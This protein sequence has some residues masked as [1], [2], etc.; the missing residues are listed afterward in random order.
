MSEERFVS[1]RPMK[2]PGVKNPYQYQECVACGQPAR[3]YAGSRGRCRDCYVAETIIEH[4]TENSAKRCHCDE[5]RAAA[6]AARRRRRQAN[7]EA[8]RAYDRAYR[9]GRR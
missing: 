6:V 4:G 7:I 2:K 3:R 9:A 5:C 8:A 1:S